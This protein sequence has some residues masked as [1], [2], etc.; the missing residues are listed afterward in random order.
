MTDTAPTTDVAELSFEQAQ[1]ELEQIV[2]QLEDQQTGLEQALALWER[3][4]A[5]HA[6]CQSKL[7]HA[8]ERIQRL[9]VSNEDVAEVLAEGG[10]DFARSEPADIAAPDAPAAS[11]GGEGSGD[12]PSMF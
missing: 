7:D 8:A 2:E 6:Y 4:E 3:G 11:N 12:M 10:D 5:L 9:T 1:A